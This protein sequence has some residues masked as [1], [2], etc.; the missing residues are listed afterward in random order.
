MLN[1][2]LNTLTS[3]MYRRL[4]N[5]SYVPYGHP[6][7]DK[8]Y[9]KLIVELRGHDSE[10]LNSYETFVR[11]ASAWL[12]I[13]LAEI[14]KPTRSIERYSILKSKFGHKKHF[15]QYEFRTY[16]REIEFSNLTGSTLSTFLE[17]IQRNLP[18]G[19]MMITHKTEIN[20]LPDYLLDSKETDESVKDCNENGTD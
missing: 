19:V 15:K 8:L 5:S 11:T 6:T 16:F 7:A 3:P 10:V 14:R 17:Y 2:L 20:P 12:N 13:D 9:K 4:C 1:R 18:E